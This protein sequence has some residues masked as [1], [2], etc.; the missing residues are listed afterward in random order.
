MFECEHNQEDLQR[1]LS[2][3]ILL[4][5]AKDVQVWEHDVSCSFSVKSAY[6]CLAKH[7]PATETECCKQLRKIKALPKVMVTT[8]RVLLDIIPTRM[9][10]IRR[11]VLLNSYTCAICQNAGESSQHLFVEC[12]IAQQ[13]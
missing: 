8:W 7:I 11:G 9:C 5:E 4:R 12:V 13:V 2:R 6:E 1:C 3:I 10:L